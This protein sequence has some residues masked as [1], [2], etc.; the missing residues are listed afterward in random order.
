LA[1]EL[2]QEAVTVLAFG[3]AAEDIARIC[4]GHPG[5]GEA[6]KEAAMAVNGHA[7]HI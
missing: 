1:G 5:M 4:H 3:G 7:I 6:V 2:I